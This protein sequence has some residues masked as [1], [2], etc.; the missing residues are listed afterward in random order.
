[1]ALLNGKLILE[2]EFESP[3]RRI[4]GIYLFPY[5]AIPEQ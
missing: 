3:P 1:M 4:A 5:S 2:L